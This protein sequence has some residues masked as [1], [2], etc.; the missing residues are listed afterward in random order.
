MERHLVFMDW[1][2]ILLTCSQYMIRNTQYTI[3]CIGI[4]FTIHNT[5]AIYKFNDIPIGTHR[6]FF[7]LQ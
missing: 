3:L 5:K 7:F 4:V 6:A 1:K 2:T